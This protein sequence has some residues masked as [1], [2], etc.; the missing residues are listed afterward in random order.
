MKSKVLLCLVR[1]YIENEWMSNKAAQ[2]TRACQ[3]WWSLGYYDLVEVD[4]FVEINNYVKDYDWIVVQSAGDIITDS[5]Y[6]RTKLESIPENVGLIAH[7]LFYK[8]DDNSPYIH[9]QCFIINCKAIKRT[10]TFI[11]KTD[12]GKSFIRSDEDLHDGHAPLSV[13]YGNEI[14]ERNK[15]FGSDLI[16]EV[17]NNGYK[18]QNF[19]I[20]WRFNPGKS[21]KGV[22]E[23]IDKFGFP[24][25][26]TR[27][28]IWPELESDHYEQAFKKL[29]PNEFLDPLQT[30]IIQLFKNLLDY[31]DL[32]VIHW[33]KFE[34]LK[35]SN[36]VIS[37]A[38]GLLGESLCLHSNA[39]KIIFYDVNKNNIEFKKHLYTNWDGKDYFNFAYNYA[40]EKNLNIEPSTPNGIEESL[41]SKDDTDKVFKNWNYIKSLEKEFLHIDIIKDCD[42][43]ISRI[44][45][46]TVIHTST[47]FNYYL[48]S[49]IIH[50]EET[51]NTAI[52]KLKQKINE[53]NSTW[54]ETK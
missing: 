1:S 36:C 54:I 26:P 30:A 49:N 43:I 21:N 16:I 24:S 42:Q 31:N 32:N 2:L 37:P 25:I 35:N 17:L 11:S 10:I 51:I 45:D 7:I 9:H 33:D 20:S 52:K 4:N 38:N 46:N 22:E 18:V 5:D 14:I 40:K 19:D 50:D 39:N 34:E 28:Y 41:K 12:T 44:V 47:I 29:E 6:L 48:Q 53:T 15:K 8:N 3:R 23:L 13:W 27:G